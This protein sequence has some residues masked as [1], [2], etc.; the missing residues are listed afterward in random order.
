MAGKHRVIREIRSH[1]V[2]SRGNAYAC[3][4]CGASVA[5]TEGHIRWHAEQF[6]EE[7]ELDVNAGAVPL[8]EFDAP[9]SWQR[10]ELEEAALDQ[11]RSRGEKFQ[12]KKAQRRRQALEAE[13]VALRQ[14]AAE[15]KRELA[16]GGEERGANAS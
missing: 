13:M 14:R 9:D 3:F 2:T 8:T 15:I 5:D 1:P 10:A 12:A 11:A 6:G 16:D 7:I 4:S